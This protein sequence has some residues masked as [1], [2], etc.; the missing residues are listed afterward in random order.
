MLFLLFF[1]FLQLIALDEFE[2]HYFLLYFLPSVYPIK[3]LYR[4]AHFLDVLSQIKNLIY[5]L[6]LFLL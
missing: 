5:S 2:E 3:V 6:Y 4:E 1:Y